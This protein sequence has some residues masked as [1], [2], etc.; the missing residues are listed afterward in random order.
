MTS[1][2]PSATRSRPLWTNSKISLLEY[3]DYWVMKFYPCDFSQLFI[4]CKCHKVH[5]NLSSIYGVN[6]ILANFSKRNLAQSQHL[7][8]GGSRFD[9]NRMSWVECVYVLPVPVHI[10]RISV[11]SVL[12]RWRTTPTTGEENSN[13]A[14]LI[15]EKVWMW[16][17]PTRTECSSQTHLANLASFY[18]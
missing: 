15:L 4:F 3:L 13:Y 10:C 2:K 8:E 9:C 16:M 12:V 5:N 18:C 14:V 7:T 17:Q 11:Y 6:M 1:S